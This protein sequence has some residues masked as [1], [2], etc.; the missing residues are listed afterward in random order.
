[1]DEDYARAD[2]RGLLCSNKIMIMVVITMTKTMMMMMLKGLCK[3][4]MMMTTMMLK[5]MQGRTRAAYCALT[6]SW[7]HPPPLDPGNLD[8]GANGSRQY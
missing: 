3:V 2:S 7:Q 4:M 5:I 6:R 1:M 8:T